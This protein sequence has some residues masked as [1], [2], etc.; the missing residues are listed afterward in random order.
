MRE[1]NRKDAH[2]IDKTCR[3]TLKK[4]RERD[5]RTLLIIY[6]NNICSS[7]RV[8]LTLKDAKRVRFYQPSREGHFFFVGI[9]REVFHF[10]AILVVR[11]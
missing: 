11:V 4:E 7:S 9:K 2:K 5:T 6:C 3:N 1:K 8:E 10:H